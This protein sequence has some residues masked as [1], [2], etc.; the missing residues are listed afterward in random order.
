MIQQ[1]KFF[2][3]NPALHSIL[4]FSSLNCDASL[5]AQ[6]IINHTAVAV[7]DASVAS[8]SIG[9]ASWVIQCKNYTAR[10]EGRV[11][12]P[13]GSSAMNSYRAEIYGIYAILIAVK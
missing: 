8:Y 4:R 11:R 7:T 9:T 6:A 2:T 10:C 3:S 13:P 5:I 12:V 1:G